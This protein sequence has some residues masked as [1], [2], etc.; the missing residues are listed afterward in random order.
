MG[1]VGGARHRHKR[2]RLSRA[3]RARLG[4]LR[5]EN[6][7]VAGEL[8]ELGI[9]TDRP[10]VR[11]D[12]A[13]GSDGEHAERP[14]PFVGCRMHLYFEVSQ[15]TGA[16]SFNF[17]RLE[18]WELTHSC[19]LDVADEGGMTLE[20][21]GRRLNLTRERARQIEHRAVERLRV[22]AFIT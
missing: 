4:A 2:E 7:P 13:P 6:A 22:V 19:A 14:C 9:P 3:Q 10:R 1:A 18:P 12:C 8:A 21:L 15:A 5:L 11:G 17:P 20:E 16:I